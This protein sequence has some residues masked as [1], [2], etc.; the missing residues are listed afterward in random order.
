MTVGAPAEGVPGA[1][2]VLDMASVTNLR[3]SFSLDSPFLRV[4]NVLNSTVSSALVQRRGFDDLHNNCELCSRCA[5]RNKLGNVWAFVQLILR[6]TRT[7]N[8]LYKTPKI[9]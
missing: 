4:P 1:T 5:R 2:L 9:A 6:P 7:E 3:V 8:Q